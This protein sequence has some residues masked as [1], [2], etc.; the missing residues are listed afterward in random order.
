VR[1]LPDVPNGPRSIFPGRLRT[2]RQR[3]KVASVSGDSWQ[4]SVLAL[5]GISSRSL[6]A[7]RDDRG[8]SSRLSL[9]SPASEPTN[10]APIVE[11]RHANPFDQVEDGDPPISMAHRC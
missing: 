1:D 9:F 2:C 6:L 5:H 4:Q 8:T 3:R 11:G 7:G 10:V